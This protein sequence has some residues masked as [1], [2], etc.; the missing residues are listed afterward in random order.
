MSS[1]SYYSVPTVSSIPALFQHR[2]ISKYLT[3][4]YQQRIEQFYQSVIRQWSHAALLTHTSNIVDICF[5]NEQ[6]ARTWEEMTRS[7]RNN[8]KNALKAALLILCIQHY[9]DLHQADQDFQE[10][11]DLRAFLRNYAQF[12]KHESQEDK[13]IQENMKIHRFVM[14]VE[15]LFHEFHVTASHNKVLYMTI[16]TILADKNMYYCRGGSQ[17]ILLN[18][19]EDIFTSI[20]GV[21]PILKGEARLKPVETP[22]R[23]NQKEA[24]VSIVVKEEEELK[25]KKK[26]SSSVIVKMEEEDE[27]DLFVEATTRATLFPCVTPPLPIVTSTMVPY[28]PSPYHS[29]YNSNSNMTPTYPW[30]IASQPCQ[31]HPFTYP[32]YSNQYHVSDCDGRQFN[33]YLASY[34]SPATSQYSTTQ[35]SD[36]QCLFVNVVN[37]PNNYHGEPSS[38]SSSS[39]RSSG[40]T[41]EELD[42]S[43]M[44]VLEEI[45]SDSDSELIF[46]LPAP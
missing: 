2:N 44:Q 42:E 15:I 10:R 26:S 5:P 6:Y 18:T 14:G 4:A 24:A 34:S 21:N 16:C 23:Y 8:V 11:C 17:S 19:F 22:V 32:S 38:S 46:P 37:S 3:L 12:V 20:T 7:Q 36:N 41:I 31:T 43:F 39:N 45:A 9:V 29:E 1:S 33:Q 35:H 13:F 27:E 25:E 40:N 30:T 28:P